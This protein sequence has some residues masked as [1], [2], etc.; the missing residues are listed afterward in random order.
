MRLTLLSLF[1][2]LLISLLFLRVGIAHAAS[3]FQT[4]QEAIS[5]GVVAPPGQVL[6]VR[7]TYENG[8]FTIDS[9]AV[10]KGYAPKENEFATE[11]ALVVKER[12]NEI[13]RKFFKVPLHIGAPP[14]LTGQSPIPGRTITK[15]QISEIIS[16]NALSKT[17]EVQNKS[18][19][20]L[21]TFDSTKIVQRNNTIN[22][23][24]KKGSDFNTKRSETEST[25]N[26][27]GADTGTLNITFIGHGY[28]TETLTVFHDDV[29][30][31][32]QKLASF[33]PFTQYLDHI[34]FYY[35]NNTSS[36]GCSYIEDF[37]TCNTSLAESIVQSSGAPHDRIVVLVNSG[38]YGGSEGVIPV[39]YNGQDGP[40]LFVHE[41]AHSLSE[42]SDEYL[43]NDATQRLDRNCFR[44]TPPN[45][46]W[47]GVVNLGDYVAGCNFA[48]DYRSSQDSIMFNIGT[49]YFNS[50][51]ILYLRNSL[52]YYSGVVPTATSPVTPTTLS[53]PGDAN[54]DGKVDGI[55]FVAWLSHYNQT[56]S[57]GPSFGDFNRDGK[58]DGIDYTVWLFNYR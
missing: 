37:L 56:T 6:Q 20:V 40:S 7:M 33:T 36:L 14:P 11:Y 34:V 49:P 32:A 51:S 13:A 54:G 45:P 38:T 58:V 17:I 24:V 29:V 18:G 9:A 48:N 42:L 50:A 16:W 55:D 25:S 47:S 27:L 2:F 52:D 10:Q 19:E 22:F 46:A 21:A 35:V 28:N 3:Q 31:F 8:K 44:G 39:V 1:S 41:F 53:V 5:S 12:G 43:R 26:V 57:N 4:S 15:A 23:G 30:R